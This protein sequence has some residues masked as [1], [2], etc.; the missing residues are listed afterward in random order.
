MGNRQAGF[1]L[2]F[3]PTATT[4]F[5]F[6][7]LIASSYVAQ[8]AENLATGRVE[9]WHSPEPEDLGWDN[10][11]KSTLLGQFQQSS[12]WGQYKQAEGWSV[13]RLVVTREGGIVGGFQILWKPTRL[14]RIGYV[15]KGPV[16][17]AENPE[18]A[19]FIVKLVRA[20]ADQL[21]LR[22]LIV[23]APDFGDSLTGPLRRAGW[24]GVLPG[25]IIDASCML[26]L[27][28]VSKNL[29]TG[30]SSSA[31]RNVRI[32][33]KMGVMVREGTG[34]EITLF[35]SLMV[36]TC[37]RHGVTPNPPSVA[38]SQAL[39]SA[40]AKGGHARLTFATYRGEAIAGKLSI[41]FGSRASLFKVGWNGQHPKSHSNELL[42]SEAL[43]WAQS[44][45]YA[46]ADWVGMSRPTA[47][48]VLRG[49]NLDEIQVSSI[50]AFKL[51][52][53]GNPVL[54][55]S[56]LVWINNPLLRHGYKWVLPAL[57]AVK[58]WLQ[59]LAVPSNPST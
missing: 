9:V 32:A 19:A 22:A 18:L 2:L 58:S 36:G 16:V 57:I 49:T 52:F 42:E 17:P 44:N 20:Q 10:F 47:D 24:L 34:D 40:M 29:E 48:S 8:P 45:Q 27:R 37:A 41:L 3:H 4:L 26:D 21:K 31:R 39:W 30:F 59:R 54:L 50:D 14:G 55:P 15:S 12:G 43:R 38:A 35:H 1:F 6:I 23:Q 51:R 25:K 33:S 53:G 56:A 13:L 46:T 5:L 11:L 7:R 28:P